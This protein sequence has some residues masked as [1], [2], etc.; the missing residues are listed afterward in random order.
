MERRIEG[1]TKTASRASRVRSRESDAGRD[2][3]LSNGSPLLAQ[4]PQHGLQPHYQDPTVAGSSVPFSPGPGG[5]AYQHAQMAA[6]IKDE[7][8]TPPRP[9]FAQNTQHGGSLLHRATVMTSSTDMTVSSLQQHLSNY[10]VRYLRHVKRV[11]K[12]FT[13]SNDGGSDADDGSP[14]AHSDSTLDLS[15]LE[16]DE[17]V[18]P[19]PGDFLTADMHRSKLAAASTGMGNEDENACMEGPDAHAA[20]LCYCAAVREEPFRYWTTPFG[21]TPHAEAL[22]V[23]PLDGSPIPLTQAALQFVDR[24]GNTIA[25][26][27][28]A[29]GSAGRLFEAL[30][31]G[32]DVNARNTAGQTFLHVL[33]D[34]WFTETAAMHQGRVLPV[35]DLLRYLR[36][37]RREFD[38]YVTDV[39]GRSIFHILSARIGDMNILIRILT[40][41]DPERYAR[42]DAFGNTPPGA[43]EP[44]VWNPHAPAAGDGNGEPA[45]L[46]QQQSP[47]EATITAH[48]RL[49]EHIRYAMTNPKLE[50]ATGSNGCVGNGL[51][52]LAAAILSEDTL[53]TAA[54][55]PDEPLSPS[56]NGGPSAAAATGANESTFQQVRRSLKR[57]R[58]A[59]SGAANLSPVADGPLPA[60]ANPESF[61]VASAASVA[62]MAT[63]I[64]TA[65]AAPETTAS[66]TTPLLDSSSDRL[67][68]RRSVLHALLAAGVDPNAYDGDGETP[69]TRFARSLPEEDDYKIPG[70]ILADLVKGGADVDRRNR[71]GE[72][73]L[74]VAV[75]AGKKLVVRALVEAGG[76]RVN[77]R[78]HAPVPRAGAN[79]VATGAN[80][81]PQIGAGTGGVDAEA[82]ATATAGIAPL[83]LGARRGPLEVA[84]DGVVR[85]AAKRARMQREQQQLAEGTGAVGG[86]SVPPVVREQS[87]GSTITTTCARGELERQYA[88]LEACKAWLAGRGGGAKPMGGGVVGEWGLTP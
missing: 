28:A 8:L 52:S 84:E 38:P 86:G 1:L 63:A 24:F 3:R 10:S 18:F 17:I 68:F 45:R 34:L 27:L 75:R 9:L 40:E 35:E 15:S 32:V 47:A 72:T 29:R 48:A 55:V 78:V 87:G 12:R 13:I 6:L 74:L 44:E 51:H 39:Y 81:G 46:Q 2:R 19:L 4:Q 42:R 21:L 50:Y 66:A 62:A 7:P 43:L 56:E 16:P 65:V 80:E 67:T 36:E 88:H 58:G 85:L 76:A 37:S 71:R 77:A 61:F 31:K 64:T 54:G 82:A 53:R 14:S 20:Q 30:D 59:S 69:L 5:D 41:Y 79:A 23:N 57:K 26:M 60:N 25:H 11:M 83:R 49:L 22:L 70:Q 33:S 73:A